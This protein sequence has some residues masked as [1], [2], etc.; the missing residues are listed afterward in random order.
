MFAFA[1]GKH[2]Q[3]SLILR[4]RQKETRVEYQTAFSASFTRK[5]LTKVKMHASDKLFKRRSVHD[6]EKNVFIKLKLMPGALTG[7]KRATRRRR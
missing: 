5:Q 1:N 2:F 6:D 7:T 3:S 4:L